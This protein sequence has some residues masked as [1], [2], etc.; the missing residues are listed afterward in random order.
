M[1]W[2]MTSKFTLMLSRDFVI[3]FFKPSDLITTLTYVL[4]NNFCPCFYAY[5][6]EKFNYFLQFYST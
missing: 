3:F 5:M 4:I 1:R 6:I 2:N